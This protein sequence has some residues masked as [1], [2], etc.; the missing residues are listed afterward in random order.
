[1][2]EDGAGRRRSDCSYSASVVESKDALLG[3]NSLKFRAGKSGR[4]MTMKL[5][6]TLTPGHGIFLRKQ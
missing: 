5:L 1:M 6:G 4:A 3:E 2:E